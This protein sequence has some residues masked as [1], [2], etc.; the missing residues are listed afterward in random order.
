MVLDL[1]PI[2]EKLLYHSGI[3]INGKLRRKIISE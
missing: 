3:E 1:E 2:N